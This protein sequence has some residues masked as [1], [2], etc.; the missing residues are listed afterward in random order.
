MSYLNN[1]EPNL[2]FHMCVDCVIGVLF[3]LRTVI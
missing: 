3:Y 2:F 1:G